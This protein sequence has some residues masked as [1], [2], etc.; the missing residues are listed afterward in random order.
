[1]AETSLVRAW[2]DRFRGRLAP[3]PCPFDGASVLESPGRS[4]IAGPGK[5]LGAFGLSAGE[6]ALE[7]GPGIGYYSVD[8]AGRVGPGGWLICLDVQRDMLKE[9]RRR[10]IEGGC[11]TAGVLQASAEAIPL[12][13]A[14]VDRVFLITVLGEIPDRAK[15]LSEIY[16]VLRTG[17]RLSVS[18]QIPDPDYITRSTLRR[19]LTHVGFHEEA[20]R[21]HLVYTSTWRKAP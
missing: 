19:E 21:G 5:I 10:L 6:R 9:T 12:A 13:A 2:L 8:A 7:I 17:G 18:E 11:T 4:W 1:M 14:V 20:T 15:A 16:R 3:V